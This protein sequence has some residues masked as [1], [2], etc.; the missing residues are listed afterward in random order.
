[1]GI[2]RITLG[3]LL[4]IIYLD[5]MMQDHQ[6]MND[7]QLPQR[8]NIQIDPNAHIEELNNSI[9]AQQKQETATSTGTMPNASK[10]RK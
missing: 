8:N 2:S 7:E 9:S 3:A 5:D 4:C 6:A 10:T 1:M